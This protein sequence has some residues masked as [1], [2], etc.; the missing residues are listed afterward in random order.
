MYRKDGL[1]IVGV[2]TPEFAFEAEPS[3]VRAAIKRLG[4]PLSGRARPEVRHLGPLGQPVLAG[5]VPDR[6]QR[7]RP[8]RA[9]RRGRVRPDREHDPHAARREAGRAGLRRTSRDSTP[10][11]P[12][13]ARVVPR[14]RAAR[15]LHRLEDPAGQ[16]GALRVP[17]GL[18]LSQLTYAG[19]LA[20]RDGSGSSPGRGARLRLRFYAQDAYL[21]LGGK[22][23]VQVLVDGKPGH[24]VPVTADKLYTVAAQSKQQRH[25]ARAA[26]LARRRGLRLHVRLVLLEPG[27]AGVVRAPRA[28]GG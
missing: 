22:G 21:V 15:A 20:G 2:H 4:D 10:A 12:T 16:D 23:R 1:V 3:N 6:P 17:E 8:P 18:G 28:R 5:G 26:L 7:P 13:D 11:G 19:R 24:V 27:R 25:V 9:L 14:L